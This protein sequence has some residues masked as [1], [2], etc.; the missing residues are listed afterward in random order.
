MLFLH[1]T[2]ILSAY[3][4]L[5]VENTKLDKLNLCRGLLGDFEL[6]FANPDRFIQLGEVLK[7]MKNKASD[8]QILVAFRQIEVKKFV[9][10]SYLETS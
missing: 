5:F 6:P 1:K 9:G 4:A 3:S 7:L 10:L 8:G 2:F